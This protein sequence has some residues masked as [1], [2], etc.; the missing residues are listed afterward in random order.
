M[1]PRCLTGAGIITG[2]GPRPLR[3]PGRT[4]VR[5]DAGSDSR[6]TVRETCTSPTFGSPPG[7][8]HRQQADRTAQIASWRLAVS[9]IL[10]R[11]SSCRLAL[12]ARWKDLD[13]TD[14]GAITA[15]SRDLEAAVASGALSTVRVDARGRKPRLAWFARSVG[16]GAPRAASPSRASCAPMPCSTQDSPVVL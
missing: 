13:M 6:E 9:V 16:V 10:A 5:S 8:D 2:D 11:R 4:G 15:F 1:T 3:N 7:D 14:S 12:S